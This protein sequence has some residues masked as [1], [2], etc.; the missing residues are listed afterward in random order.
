MKSKF[1]L[2]FLIDDDIDDLFIHTRRINKFN[3][4][5]R[6]FTFTNAE[7][8]LGHLKKADSN[9]ELSL[10][11][12]IFLDINMPRMNAWR[13]LE[14]FDK[15]T[16]K[17]KNAISIFIL[18]SSSDISDENRAYYNKN[19]KSFYSKPITNEMLYNIRH[20]VLSDIF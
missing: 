11:E 1:D 5:E 12:I 14:E 3:F 6:L 9:T 16:E 19:V 20:Y 13:F 18:T 17:A 4:A 15:L 2:V 10:P 7:E 8:A